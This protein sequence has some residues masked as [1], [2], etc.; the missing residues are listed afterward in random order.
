MSTELKDFLAEAG[1][2]DAMYDYLAARGFVKLK[3]FAHA[4]LDEVAFTED[5]VKPYMEGCVIGETSF[6][7]KGDPTFGASVMRS[8][9]ADAK[10]A[11]QPAP[12]PVAPA[13]AT[14]VAAS[15][16]GDPQTSDKVPKGLKKGEWQTQV[17]K[18]ET[19]FVPERK[20]PQ[21]LLLG[22]EEV[23]ARLR[24]ELTESRI[25]TPLGLGEI[26]QR[27]AF[28]AQGQVNPFLAKAK[29]N[30]TLGWPSTTTS[31]HCL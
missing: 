16:A 26:L 6:K 15:A 9:W 19:A 4:A 31:T 11:L 29:E 18:F 20:F 22:A 24:H 27:R 3:F 1:A 25:F 5:L 28:T 7:F 21:N 2:P 13:P 23:L 14:P 10:A 30:K 17:R 12:P 8:V